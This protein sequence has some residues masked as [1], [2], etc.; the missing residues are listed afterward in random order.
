MMNRVVFW[1]SYI[2]AWVYLGLFF[3]ASVAFFALMGFLHFGIGS[4]FDVF[5]TYLYGKKY[6][7][8]RLLQAE[9]NPIVISEIRINGLAKGLLFQYRH[10]EYPATLLWAVLWF[11][12]PVGLITGTAIWITSGD[13]PKILLASLNMIGSFHFL[14]GVHN[15]YLLMEET[16]Q[17]HQTTN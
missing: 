3:Q 8:A 16:N 17:S 10:R 9:Q 2:F 5:S 15:L 11:V 4:A 6:G 13:F 12:V 7:V 14:A 1:G